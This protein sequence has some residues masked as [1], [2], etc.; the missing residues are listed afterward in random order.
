MVLRLGRWTNEKREDRELQQI[1]LELSDIYNLDGGGLGNQLDKEVLTQL[2]GRWI[3]LLL[4]R[5][6]TWRLKSRA[7]WLTCGYDNTK[8]FH[9]YA[10]GREAANTVWSLED[11]QGYVH[12]T[13]ESMASTGVGHF[14]KLYKALG[15]AS[16]A[17]FIHIAQVSLGL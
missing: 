7:I 16:L 2:E 11:E 6:E 8:N 5:E 10:T 12:D 15:Q 9:A 3:T 4:E 17:K 13:F 1:E 14:K